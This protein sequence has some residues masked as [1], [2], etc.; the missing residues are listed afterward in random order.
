MDRVYF[1]HEKLTDHIIRIR[2]ICGTFLY[3]VTGDEKAVLLDTGDGFGDLRAYVESLTD[4]PVTVILTHGHLDHACGAIH[5]K[6]CDIW[7]NPDD[8]PVYELHTS[9]EYR[10]KFHEK[11]PEVNDIPLSEYDP[12]YTGELLRLHDNQ[13][14]DLGNVHV[15]MVS[16]KGH[17]PGM[18]CAL[19]EED[20]VMLFGDACGV[21]VLLFDEYS[22]TVSEYRNSL[23]NLKKYEERYDRIIRNHGT[24]ESPK[25]LLDNVIE[26]CDLIL[27][28]KDDHMPVEFNGM[29]L[30]LA[31]AAE[32]GV[33]LDG[34]EGNIA[35]AADKRI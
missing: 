11:R 30:Y 33:R 4:L 21:F 2:D 35:Y 25:E 14:F 18:M 28:E 27:A 16:V 34:K 15:T 31:H 8:M 9:F 5:F 10:R 7:M 29:H 20:R 13:R 19:I 3:L 6:D 1:T 32:N 23:L 12:P 26:C 24:G 17:T 22:S